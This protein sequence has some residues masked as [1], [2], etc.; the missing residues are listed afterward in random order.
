MIDSETPRRT[1]ERGFCL[2]RAMHPVTIIALVA[3]ICA[4]ILPLLA[5]AAVVV[6]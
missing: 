5:A 2:E 3:C 1:R 6:K 4:T